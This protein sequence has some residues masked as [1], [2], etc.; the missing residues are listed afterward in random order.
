MLVNGIPI[1]GMQY[2]FLREVL[3]AAR[4]CVYDFFVVPGKG[5]VAD[6]AGV[7]KSAGDYQRRWY[8]AA[9]F[10]VVMNADYPPEVRDQIF[11]EII[12]ASPTAL[13]VLN[14]VEIP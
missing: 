7:R 6:M 13:T 10:Q 9:Q 14:T 5:V 2:E 1:S 11:R 4:Q 12:G 8:G 3:P